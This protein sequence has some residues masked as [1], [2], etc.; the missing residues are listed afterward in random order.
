MGWRYARSP[1]DSQIRTTQIF[2][3]SDR[4]QTLLHPSGRLKSRHSQKSVHPRV[5]ARA[6]QHQIGKFYNF[7]FIDR[8][9]SQVW[10]CGAPESDTN[11]EWRTGRE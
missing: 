9:H 8:L 2:N 11:G 5:R 10:G 4:W 7:V 3:L 6:G 1:F